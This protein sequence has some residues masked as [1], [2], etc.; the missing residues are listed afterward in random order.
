MLA[1]FL[2]I[3]NDTLAD[4]LIAGDHIFRGRPGIL[5]LYPCLQWRVEA[6]DGQGLESLER[7]TSY[8]REFEKELK[9]SCFN[10]YEQDNLVINW[11][12]IH[13]TDKLPSEEIKLSEMKE[14]S[15]D[16]YEEQVTRMEQTRAFTHNIPGKTGLSVWMS[17]LISSRKRGPSKRRRAIIGIK[18]RQLKGQSSNASHLFGQ[19]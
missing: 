8:V 3:K 6:Y 17:W 18:S 12:V 4:S 15:E 14:E 2:V 19:K 1:H 5:S 9:K 16:G 7:M 11:R 13:T 10:I